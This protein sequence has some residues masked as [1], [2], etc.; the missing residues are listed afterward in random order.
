MPLGSS[1]PF[2]CCC[3]CCLRCRCFVVRPRQNVCVSIIR[4]LSTLLPWPLHIG[5]NAEFFFSFFLI[6][7][8][9]LF[10]LR[11][12]C[13]DFH[14]RIC[15]SITNVFDLHREKMVHIEQNKTKRNEKK[16]FLYTHTLTA[17]RV[18][19]IAYW[20]SKWTETIEKTHSTRQSVFVN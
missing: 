11:F 10:S 18:S 12:I 3:C 13:F 1:Y 14:F 15:V 17:H 16:P 8:I 20:H 6:H 7:F 2:F 4:I 5:T 19:C 9:F